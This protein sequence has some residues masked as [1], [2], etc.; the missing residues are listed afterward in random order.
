V[1]KRQ[2]QVGPEIIDRGSEPG[3]VVG[4]ELAGRGR[5]H[6]VLTGRGHGVGQRDQHPVGA[7]AH[8]LGR[9]D[10]VSDHVGLPATPISDL[11]DH[12]DD[13][14]Q[15]GAV[16]GQHLRAKDVTRRPAGLHR[17]EQGLGRGERA[18]VPD[19]D[20][21]GT[22]THHTLPGQRGLQRP[23][24]HA[25]PVEGEPADLATVG[26]V[27]DVFDLCDVLT[28]EGDDREF[29]DLAGAQQ[30]AHL[31]ASFSLRS[32][33]MTPPVRRRAWIARTPPITTTM[34]ITTMTN[35]THHCT[36]HHL[37]FGRERY[38]PGPGQDFPPTIVVPRE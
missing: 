21:V 14:A 12:V 4:D 8:P 30:N 37:G 23:R 26:G 19:D 22:Q 28:G 5:H 17:G 35:H 13:D 24:E 33:M 32:L 25:A 1:V 16:I 6:Q 18:L 11:D 38:R 36:A 29:V 27:H 10:L 2:A 9:V 31:A 20:R 3:Q 34:M 15:R 7:P